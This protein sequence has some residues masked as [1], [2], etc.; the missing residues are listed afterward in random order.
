M[1]I[2]IV[3]MNTPFLKISSQNKFENRVLENPNRN[4][5]LLTA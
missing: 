5:P 4:K 2:Y 1:L 3:L